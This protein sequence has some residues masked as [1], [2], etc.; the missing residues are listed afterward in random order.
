MST[1][2]FDQSGFDVIENVVDDDCLGKLAECVPSVDSVGSRLLLRQSEFQNLARKLR[3]ATQ[4]ALFL[5]NT[6]AIQ[7][8]Y[9]RKDRDKNWALKLHRDIVFPIDGAGPWPTA[10]SKEGMHFHRPS[11]AL[12]DKLIA[13]RLHLDDAREGDLLIVP[14]SHSNEICSDRSDA[15]SVSVPKGGVLVMSPSVLHGST[16]LID[17]VSRR[18]LHFV[19]APE[20]LPYSYRWYHAI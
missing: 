13:V 19:F 18:V 4:L 7:C 12:V 3:E 20:K 6:V 14:G 8:I 11:K 16:R 2:Q 17:A 1:K 10:G 15:K 9:F 5:E